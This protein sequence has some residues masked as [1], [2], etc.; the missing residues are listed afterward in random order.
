LDPT[1]TTDSLIANWP[2]TVPGNSPVDEY[3]ILIKSDGG[4]SYTNT[5]SGDTLT[6]YFNVDWTPNWSVTV[7]AHNAAGWGPVS[8]TVNLGG[9]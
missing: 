1:G 8:S 7:R 2:A 5:V 6:T 9:L 3:L 4:S